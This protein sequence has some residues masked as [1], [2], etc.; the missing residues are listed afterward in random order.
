MFG[1]QFHG[2]WSSYTDEQRIAVLDLLRAAGIR[3]VRL[4]VSWA[5]LQPTGPTAY[6][7]WGVGFVDRVIQLCEERGITPLI[8][9]WLTPGWA[10][11]NLGERALPTD[12]ADY[13]RA[14]H[15]AADRYAGRVLGWEV[16]NEPNSAD[17]LVGASPDGYTQLL[18]A[19]YP[20]L[21][22]GDPA[23]PVVFGGVQYN[24]DDWLARAYAAGAKDSFDVMATHPYPAIADQSPDV[25]DDGTIWVLNHAAAVH[26]LMAEH[27]DAD[28]PI[29]FTEV[30]W[31]THHHNPPG[32]PNY[33]LGVS[34]ATQARYLTRTVDLIT[35]TMPYV[36]AVYWYAERDT[37]SHTYGL[38]RQDLSPKP[39]LSAASSAL[40]TRDLG[41]GRVV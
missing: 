28:K 38:L 8:T 5:M 34:E 24:D 4:D 21:R 10:N 2:M 27:G 3:T 26:R 12:P 1:V 15:W 32:T 31:S 36:T 14:A 25:P 20:A 7:P 40:H 19:A 13:A 22:A 18:R 39:S 29:W 6:D 37:P 23:A 41:V 17:F 35:T 16:W 33:A 9:L 30:G 11:G